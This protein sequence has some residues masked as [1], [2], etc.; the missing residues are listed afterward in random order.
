MHLWCAGQRSVYFEARKG[1]VVTLDT[2]IA[3]TLVV[4][5]RGA[6]VAAVENTLEAFTT[7]ERMGAYGSELDIRRSADGAL[8]VHHDAHLAD[9]RL[10]ADIAAS[11]LPEHVPLLAD[12]FAAIPTQFVNVEIKNHDDEPDFDPDQDIARA[13]VE[14]IRRCEAI[15]RVLV[16]SFD[17]ATVLAVREADAGIS[18][19]SLFW[20]DDQALVERRSDPMAEIARA[21]EHG[22]RAIHPHNPVVDA[23]FVEAARDSGLDIHVWTVDPIDRILE[24]AELGVTSVITNTPD[25]AIA[26]LS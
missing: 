21:A 2:E 12:V 5:H 24:L 1:F 10:I 9:G 25:L 17:F 4:A 20:V 16:S 23:A 13:V 19:G 18:T 15:E 7:A 14:E 22:V 26:A 6:S 3:K 8:V 11:E